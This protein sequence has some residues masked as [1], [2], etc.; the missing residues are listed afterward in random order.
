[1]KTYLLSVLGAVAIVLLAIASINL[2]VDPYDIFGDVFGADKAAP[3][4]PYKPAA[5]ENERL[6]KPYRIDREHANYIVLGSSRS[7]AIPTNYCVSDK[8]HGLN[9]ALA[10]G[11]VYE[12]YRMFQY[13]HHVNRLKRVV[14]GIDEQLRIDTHPEFDEGR[15]P[16][17]ANGEINHARLETWAHDATLALFT[18]DALRGSIKTMR[19][20]PRKGETIDAFLHHDKLERV[21][22]AGGHHEMFR[23]MEASVMQSFGQTTADTCDA[24]GLMFDTQYQRAEVYLKR[25]LETAYRDNI[26]VYLYFTPMHARLQEAWCMGGRW[27]VI[28]NTKRIVVR[29]VESLAERYGKTPFPVWDFSGYNSVTTEPLTKQGDVSARMKYYWEDS[30]FNEHTAKLILARMYGCDDDIPGDFGVQLKSGMLEQHLQLIR[31][32][33]LRYARSHAADIDEVHS[34]AGY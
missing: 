25:M 15:N 20:Q 8:L 3:R 23:T 16:V 24:T 26:H 33:H 2:W 12:A 18:L 14:I 31:K 9:L 4:Y 17:K 29:L 6:S 30:H 5:D 32:Q 21:I 11:S 10:S 22:R 1:M 28:E 13:A 34:L 7:L 27:A 19:Y